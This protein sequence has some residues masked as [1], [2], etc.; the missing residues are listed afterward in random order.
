MQT[1]VPPLSDVDLRQLR[2]FRAVVENKG[3]TRA[4]ET[5]GISRST[6][7][8]QMAAL[9]TR[10]GL[11]LCRRG[12][13]GFALTEH[14]DRVYAEAIKFFA[15]AESF[16]A[17]VGAIRG[18]MVGE[19]KI[20][21]VDAVVEN[22]NCRLKDAIALFNERVPDVHL[23]LM[24]V[25]P[26]H[27][28]NA[29][30]GG[31]MEIAVVPNLPINGAVHLETLFYEDQYLYCGRD[32]PLFDRARDRLPIEEIAE[33]QYVRRGYSVSAA[34]QSLF[35][36]APNA[37]AYDMEG[38]AH[39]ILSGRFVSFLPVYYADQWVQNDE[40][41]PLRPDL[42]SFKVGLCMAHFSHTVMSRI[43]RS[44]RTCLLEAHS[45]SAQSIRRST[46]T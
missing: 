10:L 43:A 39:L 1:H 12:R 36:H 28:E 4:Q 30:L 40:M 14:G 17:E 19:L 2:I 18:A 44:F 22:P 16:R 3:F 38:V 33:Q 21:V 20:G 24:I 29:L 13:S 6:I 34:H 37:T 42:V 26:N 41:R 11:K 23:T 7:S 45:H 32:H 25:S 15:A 8:S 31:Q 46:S 35:K 9:E 5:L 27:I